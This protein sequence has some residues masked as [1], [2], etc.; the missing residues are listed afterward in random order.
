MFQ[1][2]LKKFDFMGIKPKLYIK[3]HEKFHT[4]FGGILSFFTALILLASIGYFSNLL[5]SR[6]SLILS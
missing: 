6:T 2:F 5:F 3:N 1:N 4:E